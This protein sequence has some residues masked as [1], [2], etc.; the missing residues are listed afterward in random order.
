M[1]SLSQGAY[2][3]NVSQ[4]RYC[5]FMPLIILLPYIIIEALAFWLVSNWIGV[6]PALLLLIACLFIGAVIAAWQMRSIA[7]AAARRPEAMG[8]TAGDFGLTAAGAIFMA[9]PGFVTSII[10]LLLM[11]PPTR[12]IL[13]GMLAKKLRTKI[14][15]VGVRSFEMTNQYRQ[16]TSYGNF[17]GTVIDD[18]DEENIQKWTR[19][20]RPEDFGSSDNG[21]SK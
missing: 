15:E 4:Y 10:G 17:G 20:V 11:L 8:K 5:G 13:R 19:N 3:L 14:E 2:H 12:A 7:M 9:M 1:D 21:N 6:G 18:D 16:Q